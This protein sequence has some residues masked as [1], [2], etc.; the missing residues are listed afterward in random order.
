MSADLEEA[1]ADE[2][3]ANCGKAAVDEIK[4]KKCACKLVKYCSVECQKNHRPKHKKACKKRMAEI[5][6]DKLFRQP[7]ESHLGECSICC[8]PLP[9]EMKKSSIN[10][11]CCKIIC[12]GCE[13]ANRLRETRESLEGRCAF[14]RE[15]IPETDEEAE[16]NF[17]KRLK[18][19]DPRA[20]C[21][22]GKRRRESGDYKGAVEYFTNAA[23]LGD[24]EAHYQLAFAY[25]VGGGVEK[26]NKKQLYHLE[27]AA[28]GGHPKARY[29]L[30]LEEG[31][32]GRYD[33]AGKHLI[34]AAKLGYDE[35]LAA[36][37]KGFA[38]GLVSKDDYET[39][40]RGHQAAVDETKSEQRNAAAKAKELKNRG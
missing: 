18:V 15:P 3:C 30:A 6:D 35:A 34:I 39:A 37:K 13:Y 23:V 16:K 19:N 26:D 4:L 33:R 31:R 5:R 28:I 27:E 11:C 32:D 25:H 38:A 17:M 24:I 20:I 8:L 1:T 29:N 21:G 10:S 2:V 36:I 40:L 7:D 12:N 9:L 14:C 22:F